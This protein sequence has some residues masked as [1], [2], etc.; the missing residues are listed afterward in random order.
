[1]AQQWNRDDY[2]GKNGSEVCDLLNKMGAA[3][4]SGWYGPTA[5][6]NPIDGQVWVKE[7]GA[8]ADEV[9][10]YDGSSFVLLAR[11]V[12]GGGAVQTNGTVG[13]DA[14]VPLN[15]NLGALKNVKRASVAAAPVGN[16]I[17]AVEVVDANDVVIGEIPIYTK[18][19]T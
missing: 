2:V 17:F 11:L 9:Y 3:I 18:W 7:N 19:S 16:P 1:M 14:G 5:P 8:S 12:N 6:P 13:M 10:R 4:D 15:L